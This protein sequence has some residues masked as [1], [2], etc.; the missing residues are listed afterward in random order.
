MTRSD[1]LTICAFFLSLFLFTAQTVQS[2]SIKEINR[3]ISVSGGALLPMLNFFVQDTDSKEP[4]SG[5]VIAITHKSKT[6]HIETIN[7]LASIVHKFKKDT[8]AISA[9][10]MGYEDISARF[11]LKGSNPQVDISMKVIKDTLASL[12][13]SDKAIFMVSRGDTIIYNANLLETRKGDDLKSVL[14]RLPGISIE[15]GRIMHSGKPISKILVNGTTLFGNNLDAAM[16]LLYANEVTQVKVFDEHDRDRLVE[17]DTLGAKQRVLDVKT[18]EQKKKVSSF[19]VSALA[20][21]YIDEVYDRTEQASYRGNVQYSR[22]EVDKPH[23]TAN[24]KY[25]KNSD[26]FSYDVSK[27]PV[28][29]GKASLHLNRTRARNDILSANL[30][31]S[32]KGESSFYSSSNEYLLGKGQDGRLDKNTSLSDKDDKGVSLNAYYTKSLGGRSKI[33]S[34]ANLEFGTYQLVSGNGSVVSIDG[35]VLRNQYMNRSITE[36][37][38]KGLFS[39]TF[40]SIT[41]PEGEPTTGSYGFNVQYEGCYSTGAENRVDTLNLLSLVRMLS[42]S[43]RKEHRPQLRASYTKILSQKSLLSFNASSSLLSSEYHSLAD[44]LVKERI[45]TVNSMDYKELRIKNIFKI[46]YSHG[47]KGEP[48]YISAGLDLVDEEF[49]LTDKFPLQ[50]KQLRSLLSALPSIS[51]GFSKGNNQV[52]LQYGESRSLPQTL[53][54]KD[55]LDNSSPIYLRS[56]NPDLKPQHQRHI[57][58]SYDLMLMPI[59]TTFSFS[60]RYT[61]ITDYISNSTEA[62]LKDTFYPQ[63]NYWAKAGSIHTRPVNAGTSRAA[64]M[65]LG[66]NTY[67]SAL[68]V[69]IFPKLSFNT[70]DSPYFDRGGKHINSFIG[71]SADLSSYLYT[72]KVVF[73]G[74][75]TFGYD[76]T[77]IDGVRKYDTITQTA[78]ASLTYFALKN[79]YLSASGSYCD[80]STDIDFSISVLDIDLS[81]GYKFG[82][83]NAYN[84]SL[85][86]SDILNDDKSRTIA[87]MDDHISIVDRS[88]LG[89]ALLLSLSFDFR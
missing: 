65:S 32:L 63:Y 77:F 60:G 13:F 12:V 64:S 35:N 76:R 29:L 4:L 6:Y 79:L 81:L 89:R 28:S 73:S 10:L 25:M 88:L 56:G 71:G 3:E 78:V 21:A 86:I 38:G 46:N 36:G 55:W 49:T 11:P 58:L 74:G 70:G 45:D 51:A 84:I 17:A 44:D 24:L 43:Q 83:N 34:S 30:D 48:F 27:S 22:F 68:K 41:G 33:Y 80:T 57:D 54:L 19:A 52:N 26:E 31:L 61:H 15:N 53:E 50:K 23:Y 47:K 14:M 8:I 85:Q 20:G 18:K 75:Y 87:L 59:S 82:P 39:L 1:I 72:S 7:G 66:S 69:N 16:T 2:Q 62:L 9:H 40:S 37:K 42:A 5:V 67:V